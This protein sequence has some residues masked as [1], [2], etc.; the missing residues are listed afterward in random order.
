MDKE[1]KQKLA[2]ALGAED[3]EVLPY[4]PYLLQDLQ[5]LGTPIK[6]LLDMIKTHIPDIRSAKVLDLGAGKGCVGLPLASCTGAYVFMVDAFAEFIEYAQSK[7]AETGVTNCAFLT[8]DITQTVLAARNYDLVLLCSVGNV[9]GD[10][11]S[12]A[13]IEALKQTVKSGG[14]I[15]I[16]ESYFADRA[17]DVKCKAEYETLA[18]WMRSFEKAGVRL[19][20]SYD[21]GLSEDDIDF[22]RDNRHI[23]WRADELSA[24]YPDKKELFQGYVQSQLN[25]CNDLAILKTSIWLLQVEDQSS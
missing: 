5:N 24:K 11:S 14:Y 6:P 4:L 10:F 23:R 17:F 19:V 25:E 1:T 15:I 9:F 16:E 3:T 22:D 20:A 7:A 13:T 12:L 18:D 21:E 2:R 8:E